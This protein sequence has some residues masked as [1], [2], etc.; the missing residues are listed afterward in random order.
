MEKELR[1][2]QRIGQYTRII[3]L[4]LFWLKIVGLDAGDQVE[5]TMGKNK[6]LIVTP[7]RGEKDD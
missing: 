7:H 6:E 4:P 3:T 2:I 5:I 1:T